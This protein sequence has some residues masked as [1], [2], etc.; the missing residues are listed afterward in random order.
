VKHLTTAS[1]WV[2]F[3]RPLL[4]S[5]V[6]FCMT[7]RSWSSDRTR[8]LQ[9][10]R[11]Y[12]QR[13]K[14]WNSLSIRMAMLLGDLESSLGTTHITQH[15]RRTRALHN[16]LALIDAHITSRDFEW[17]DRET[18][19]PFSIDCWLPPCPLPSMSYRREIQHEHSP[20]LY[21]LYKF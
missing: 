11:I 14:R 15:D 17:R 4:I 2:S 21:F 3:D 20:K 6:S 18:I 16:V 19:D 7:S 9:A 12:G 13:N 5:S 1:S 10:S 8:S